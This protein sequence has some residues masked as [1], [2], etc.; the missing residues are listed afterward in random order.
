MTP[1]FVYLLHLA[2]QG[3]LLQPND[4]IACAQHMCKLQ[5]LKTKRNIW[6]DSLKEILGLICI[7]LEKISFARVASLNKFNSLSKIIAFCLIRNCQNKIKKKQV[8]ETRRIWRRNK[9]ETMTTERN[10]NKT[11]IKWKISHHNHRPKQTSKEQNHFQLDA[12]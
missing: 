4:G 6:L 1:K 12:K 2:Y 8:Q 11:S 7:F 10:D 5:H 3:I 9:E